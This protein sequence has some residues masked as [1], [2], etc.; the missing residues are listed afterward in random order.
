MIDELA[1]ALSEREI[2]RVDKGA[3]GPV[4]GD[5]DSVHGGGEELVVACV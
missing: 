3:G 2:G 4:R 5:A 1:D